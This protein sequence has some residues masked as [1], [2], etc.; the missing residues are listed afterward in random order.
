MILLSVMLGII[1]LLGIVW[2]VTSGAL[3][4]VGGLFMTLIMLSLCGIL[5]LNAFLDFRKRLHSDSATGRK[6]I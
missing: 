4:T 5:F 1:P 3:D 2:T 6:P